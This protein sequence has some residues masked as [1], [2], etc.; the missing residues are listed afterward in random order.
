M[1]YNIFQQSDIL[2]NTV[3]KALGIEPNDKYPWL[4]TSNMYF[5]TYFY[6]SRRFGPPKILD[7]LK[8]GGTWDFAVKNYT[9]RICLNSSWVSFIVFGEYRLQNNFIHSGFWV[10]K[11]REERKKNHLLIKELEN[12]SERTDYENEQIQILLNEFQKEQNIPDDIT[13]EE[14]NDTYGVQFWY[15]KINDFN[16]KIID[17][18]LEDYEEHGEYSNSKTRHAL[19]TLD[20]FIKNM[21]TPIYIRDRAFNIKGVLTD[22]ESCDLVRYE[23]NIKIEYKKP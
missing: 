4:I 21:L 3:A 6:L 14:F 12:P 16:N 23:N 2:Q 22:K 1:K 11:Q 18:K 7:D 13:P 19:K 15:D 20:Q 17:V 9:I 10:K 8:D 5:E